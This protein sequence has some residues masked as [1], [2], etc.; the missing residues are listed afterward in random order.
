MKY[1]RLIEMCIDDIKPTHKSIVQAQGYPSHLDAKLERKMTVK[2]E[3]KK[4]HERRWLSRAW[5]YVT[6]IL[7][8]A[9]RVAVGKVTINARVVVTATGAGVAVAHFSRST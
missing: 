6:G 9:P 5:D 4:A 7:T 8:P 2:S 3:L 1:R